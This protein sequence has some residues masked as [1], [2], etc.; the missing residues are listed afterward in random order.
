MCAAAI[1]SRYSFFGDGRYLC[2]NQQYCQYICSSACQSSGCLED[3]RCCNSN[4]LGGCSDAG[5]DQKCV[6]C[7]N[8][9]YNGV[10]VSNCTKILDNRAYTVTL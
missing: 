10:C 3:G 9:K 1:T 4:C 7:K 2:W 5:S 6:A 8:Y